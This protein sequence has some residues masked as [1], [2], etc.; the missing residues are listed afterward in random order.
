M[1]NNY[2]FVLFFVFGLVISNIIGCAA[3]VQTE[4]Y[5]EN[6]YISCTLI[7]VQKSGNAAEAR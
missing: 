7:A 1:K 2:R 3:S 5:V 4:Q 6:I